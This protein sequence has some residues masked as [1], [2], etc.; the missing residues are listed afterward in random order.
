MTTCTLY[1]LSIKTRKFEKTVYECL[2]DEKMVTLCEPLSYPDF[3]RLMQKSYM[4][5]SDSGGIQ[6]E[7]TA[8]QKPLLIL[9][10]QSERPEATE[11]GT[12]VLVGTDTDNIIRECRRLIENCEHYKTITD[13]PN[14][15]F[16]DGKAA[17]RITN[18]IRSSFHKR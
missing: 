4:I 10:C 3:V 9:R 1:S 15:P 2:S 8:L 6:E 12:G 16:G 5:L 14:N 17:E 18:I 7:A 13:K 11:L